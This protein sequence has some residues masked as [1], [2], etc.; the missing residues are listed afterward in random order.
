MQPGT[1]CQREGHGIRRLRSSHQP[2]RA[3]ISHRHVHH[4]R[5]TSFLPGEVVTAVQELLAKMVI[6]AIEA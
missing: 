6:N 1:G 4:R 2:R 5:R 3:N